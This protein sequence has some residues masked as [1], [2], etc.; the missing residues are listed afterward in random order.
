MRRRSA[1]VVR[2][3]SSATPTGRSAS[4]EPSA[5]TGQA[6]EHPQRAEVVLL[7]EHFGRRHERALVAALHRDEQ[8]RERDD[9]LA[10]TDVALQE[11]VHRRG[12]GEVVRDLG[13]R[14]LLVAGERE[15]QLRDERVDERTVDRRGGSPTPRPRTRACGRRD[16]PACAGTRRRSAGASPPP[17]SGHR[18]GPV[19]G[20]QRGVAVDQVAAIEERLVERVGE[21][22]RPGTSPARPTPARAAAT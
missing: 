6:F 8:R 7:G 13:E 14:A 17:S 12:P 18:L 1:A 11:A 19:D 3:V 5:G 22:A 2:F 20:T 16:R 15:R 9:G 4:S 21:A 10:R